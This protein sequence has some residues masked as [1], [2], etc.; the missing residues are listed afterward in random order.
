MNHHYVSLLKRNLGISG[1][2]PSL[3]IRR[4][5]HFCDDPSYE[6]E[7]YYVLHYLEKLS[8]MEKAY[9]SIQVMRVSWKN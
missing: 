7:Y 8:S 2:S 6:A 1:T 9:V 3:D 4:C 5:A